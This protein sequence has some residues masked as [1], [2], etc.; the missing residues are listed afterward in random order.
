MR[1][2]INGKARRHTRQGVVG[3]RCRTLPHP[4]GGDTSAGHTQASD[5]ARRTIKPQLCHPGP[6]RGPYVKEILQFKISTKPIKMTEYQPRYP[7][8][9]G[10]LHDKSQ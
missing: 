7:L 8:S 3:A 2:Q 6:R 9:R 5:G 4:M 1:Q 10:E